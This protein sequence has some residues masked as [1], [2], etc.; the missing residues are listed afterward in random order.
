MAS[1]LLNR[2]LKGIN[3]SLVLSSPVQ[4]AAERVKS[5]IRGAVI[6]R[7]LSHFNNRLA[8]AFHVGTIRVC[9]R[10]CSETSWGRRF[11]LVDSLLPL[12]AQ[13]PIPFE[14]ARKED[15]TR[16]RVTQI[17]DLL[18]LPAEMLVFLLE[19]EDPREIRKFS[20]RKLRDHHGQDQLHQQLI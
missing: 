1:V 3:R 20:E 11:L 13:R 4:S 9:R 16:A 5:G 19:L 10:T 7:T 18:K 8:V 12:V 6:S 17:M 2:I 15:L 14:I